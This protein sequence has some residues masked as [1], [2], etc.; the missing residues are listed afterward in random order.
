MLFPY[1]ENGKDSSGVVVK[2]VSN[3]KQSTTARASFV[4]FTSSGE[5]SEFLLGK[6]INVRSIMD[7]TI[8]R[9]FQMVSDGFI[10]QLDT[11]V[12]R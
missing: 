11:T 4:V 1:G 5:E 7:Q 6:M 10:L 2:V 9:Q 3:N 8:I 12:Y